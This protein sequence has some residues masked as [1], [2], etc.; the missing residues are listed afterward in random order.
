MGKLTPISYKQ[1]YRNINGKDQ[2]IVNFKFKIDRPVKDEIYSY[3][4]N[5]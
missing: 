2:P 4:V 3:F 5:D 1:V